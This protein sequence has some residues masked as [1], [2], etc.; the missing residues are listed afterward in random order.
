MLVVVNLNPHHTHSGWVHLPIEPWELDPQRPYQVHDLLSGARYLWHGAD[1]YIEL[2]P[3]VSPAHIFQ[4][5]RRIRRE[6][7]FDYYM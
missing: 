1:N 3:N 2:N 5:H 7:D 4:V 6:H